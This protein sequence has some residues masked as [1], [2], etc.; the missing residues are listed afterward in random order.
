MLTHQLAC[1]NIILTHC[2]LFIKTI[3]HKMAQI[4]DPYNAG[5]L[6]VPSRFITELLGYQHTPQNPK[7]SVSGSKPNPEPSPGLPE[8]NSKNALWTIRKHSRNF[9][10]NCSKTVLKFSPNYLKTVQK[11][12]TLSSK[13]LR[14]K[15]TSFHGL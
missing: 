6:L 15:F 9:N 8:N 3:T 14:L 10:P 2:M 7:T 12:R 5:H 1:I 11:I 4:L 13:N